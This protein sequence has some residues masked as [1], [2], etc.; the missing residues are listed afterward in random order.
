MAMLRSKREQVQMFKGLK[1]LNSGLV[2]NRFHHILWVEAS[3]K[4]GT[5]SR[6]GEIDYA[7]LIRG[8]TQP[9]SKRYEYKGEIKN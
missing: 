7:S 1:G 3:Q 6:S 5:D 4:I 8:T 2:H 9:H